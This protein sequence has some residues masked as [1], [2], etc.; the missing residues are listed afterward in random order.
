MQLPIRG[1]KVYSASLRIL[2]PSFPFP[3][4]PFSPFPFTSLRFPFC[5]AAL[6]PSQ[7]ISARE[8]DLSAGGEYQQC[9][10]PVREEIA[11]DASPC[12]AL[13]R[14]YLTLLVSPS[15]SSEPD[16]ALDLQPPKRNAAHLSRSHNRGGVHTHTHP[17]GQRRSCFH[18]YPPPHPPTAHLT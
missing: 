9:K 10:H 16:F 5:A 13:P 2:L 15:R 14:L 18:P 11:G 4:L 1:G 8:Q 17:H 3:S 7:E 6:P 12:L